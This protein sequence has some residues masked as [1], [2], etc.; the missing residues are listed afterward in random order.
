MPVRSSALNS[1]QKACRILRALSSPQTTRLSEIAAATS[2]NKATALR[3][4]EI[5][6]REGF[7]QRDDG[8]KSW[9]LG[10]EAYILASAASRPTDLRERA[11][12]T[13]VRLAAATEDTVLLT[14]RSRIEA[15]CI[16]REV[17]GF[18]IRANYLDIGSRRPLG[19]GAAGMALLAWLPDAEI[20]AI[21]RLV[22]PQLAPYPKITMRWI[23]REI[24]ISRNRGYTLVLDLIVE[25][26]GGVA[27]PL[28]GP[29]GRP[30]AALGVAALTERL[31]SRLDTLTALLRKEA[32]Q[33]LPSR[34][35]QHRATETGKDAE[36]V[37]KKPRAPARS[38]VR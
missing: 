3:I 27:V 7:V 37:A 18:P 17:G 33:T 16:D 30:V 9:S 22:R 10:A 34:I 25:R 2:I 15:V 31:T 4:L 19:V 11:R 12:P 26:M 13:L 35:L 8:A 21:L 5:L 38:A 29:D 36:K 32:Q 24:E 6:A 23:E 28:F 1:V 20:E 14:V